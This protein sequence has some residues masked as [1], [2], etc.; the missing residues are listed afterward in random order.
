ML[1][2]HV[3][4]LDCFP[5]ENILLFRVIL[6]LGVHKTHGLQSIGLQR[7]RHDRK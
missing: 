4:Q 2:S 3:I 1:L 7:V 5:S 6:K